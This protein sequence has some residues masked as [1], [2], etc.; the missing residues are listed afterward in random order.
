MAFSHR[1]NP[2]ESIDSI[3]P[4]CFATVGSATVESDLERIEAAHVCEAGRLQHYDE[5]RDRASK[6]PQRAE[7]SQPVE[8]VG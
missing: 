5:A 4:H 6:K 7:A 3:C 1:V 8:R 2:D